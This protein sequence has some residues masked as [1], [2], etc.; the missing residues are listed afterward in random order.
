MVETLTDHCVLGITANK[1]R[2]EM[3]LESST[4]VATALCPYLGYQKSAEI[5]KKSLKTGKT[6]RTIVLE[7]NLLDEESLTEVLDLYSMTE[8]PLEKQAI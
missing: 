1:D 3:L 2:C 7:E 6:V 5:A 8:I 4:G